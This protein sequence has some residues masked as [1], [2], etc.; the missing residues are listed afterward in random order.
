M[1]KKLKTYAGFGN[2]IWYPLK[3]SDY[4]PYSNKTSK[5]AKYQTANANELG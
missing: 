3:S 5:F 1:N 2:H 4:K